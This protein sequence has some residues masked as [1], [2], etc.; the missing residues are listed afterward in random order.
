MVTRRQMQL[1]TLL[2]L[3]AGYS[4]PTTT[5]QHFQSP[6]EQRLW[7]FDSTTSHQPTPANAT[8]SQQAFLPPTLEHQHVIAPTTL[9][10][11]CTGGPSFQNRQEQAKLA[12]GLDQ[13]SGLGWEPKW[14]D[15]RLIPWE[16][17]AYGEYAGPARTPHVPT[18]RLRVDDQIEFIFQANRERLGREY[19]LSAGDVIRVSSSVDEELNQDFRQDGITIMPDGTI[20]LELV[21]RI[22]AGNKTVAEITTEL[23]ELYAPHYDGEAKI[24][25]SAVQIGTQLNDFLNS[26]DAR[27]GSG[28]QSRQV[29]VS[30][31]GTV[32]LP[33]VGT[34]GVVGLSLDELERE[35][36]MRYQQT[37]F[38]VYV[39]PI[40]QQRAPRFIYVLGEVNEPGRFELVGPTTATQAI[41]LAGG[42]DT[43][44]NLRQIVVLRRDQNWQLMA[45]RLDLS[46][47]LFGRAPISRDEIWLRD[48]DIV[49]IP[50][51]PIQRIADLVDLYFTQ[52][53]YGIFPGE[54]G[55]FDAQSIGASN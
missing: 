3:A 17:F 47:V 50:K 41:A 38:G 4:A 6:I 13:H 39:T 29:T 18:Y 43:G 53:L 8:V 12:V 11:D 24:V 7:D 27:A 33:R 1:V 21:G 20:N 55:A 40:L 37:I 15:S 9:M 34:I 46:K 14:C 32:R 22:L 35:V 16:S 44:G 2:F 19:R 25:V 42:W 49:L 36:N 51:R 23:N 54:L 10:G 30:P 5:A 26:V 28:G 31:D 45:V 52:T 48:S